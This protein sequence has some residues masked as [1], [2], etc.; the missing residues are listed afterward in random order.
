[1]LDL[2]VLSRNFSLQIRG[3]QKLLEV[4]LARLNVIMSSIMNFIQKEKIS[5]R[6]ELKMS[7]Q[8]KGLID[9]PRLVET[10]F[11]FFYLFSHWI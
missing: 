5:S 7:T 6:K 2:L 9:F 1:M 4:K 8:K 11:L 3:N 10:S